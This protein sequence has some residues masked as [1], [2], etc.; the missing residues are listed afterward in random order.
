MAAY[1]PF[2]LPPPPPHPPPPPS[3]RPSDFHHRL[4]AAAFLGPS[5]GAV[6]HRAIAA[7]AAAAAAGAGTSSSMATPS[8]FDPSATAAAIGDFGGARP[9]AGPTD[10]FLPFGL[11]RSGF[12]GLGGMAPTL[13]VNDEVE[14]DPKVELESKELWEKFHAMETEMVITKSGRYLA[15]LN[16]YMVTLLLMYPCKMEFILDVHKSL[17]AIINLF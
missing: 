1:N 13:E 9:F 8:P 17:K 12:R 16:F 7:A 15:L 6:F 10:M 5:V 11:S 3:S 4:N 14:D 2:L